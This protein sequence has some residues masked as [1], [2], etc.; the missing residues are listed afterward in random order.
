MKH[1]ALLNVAECCQH[2]HNMYTCDTYE[3]GCGNDSLRHTLI[4]RAYTHVLYYTAA[5]YHNTRSFMR[6]HAARVVDRS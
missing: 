2:N 6:L 5:H 4:R 3:S 1:E